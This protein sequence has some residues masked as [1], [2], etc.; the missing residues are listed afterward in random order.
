MKPG[1]DMN[2]L[3][4]ALTHACPTWTDTGRIRVCSD[5]AIRV[6]TGVRRAYEKRVLGLSDM[7][8]KTTAV[9]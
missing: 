3:M 6:I 7:L 4:K 9:K 1:H 2:F 5:Q 8:S